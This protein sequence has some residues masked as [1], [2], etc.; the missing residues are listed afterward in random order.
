MRDEAVQRP[1]HPG[2]VKSVDEH[3]CGPD[4]P[5]A[6]GAEEAPE[7]LRTGPSPPRGLLLERA[8]SVK[9]ALRVEDRLHHGGAEDADQLV[10]EIGNAH[11]KP[12][13][14]HTGAI[15]VGPE[16]GPLETA[17]E[18]A[19]LRGIAKARHSDVKPLRAEQ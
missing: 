11:I 16:A 4:L 13:A 7:L 18:V 15:E 2:E 10:L 19:F 6:I 12:E 1:G 14:F 17:P 8:K 3:G 9:F 5:P